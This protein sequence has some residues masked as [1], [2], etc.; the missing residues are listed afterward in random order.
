MDVR[1]RFSGIVLV[2]SRKLICSHTLS[3]RRVTALL[4]LGTLDGTSALCLA[5]VFNSETANKKHK[6]AK[7]VTLNSP[8]KT[9]I[10]S[11]TEVTQGAVSPGSVLLALGAAQSSPCSMLARL[12]A[13]FKF[14]VTNEFH[15]GDEFTNPESMVGSTVYAWLV[16]AKSS[17]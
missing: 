12:T 16:P 5:A 2:A 4:L 15:Q 1:C 3:M 8:E 13:K 14:E 7:S 9:P 10:Y 11:R 6:N 17:G